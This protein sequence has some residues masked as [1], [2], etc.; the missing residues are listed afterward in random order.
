MSVTL[1]TPM[2]PPAAAAARS[3][4]PGAYDRMFYSGTA[5]V[6]AL[7]V[8]VGFAPTFYLRRYFGA[9]VSITGLT[10]L[11]PLTQIHGFV[12]SAWVVLFVIQTR[13]VASRHLALHRRLGVAGVV[14]AAAMV[15]VGLPTA[16]AAAARGSAPP[17]MDAK[18]FLVVPVF[19]LLL[20]AGFVTA[21]VVRRRDKETHKRLMLLGYTSI[22]PAAVGRLPGVIALGPPGLFGLS[23]LPAVAGAAYD[24]W[25]RGR[26]TPIYW[27][28]IALLYLSIPLRLAVAATPPWRAFAEFVTR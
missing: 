8:F 19:D 3:A 16:F 25:S 21:A 12:F 24:Y 27:W 28:G 20:F 2:T 14:L 11:S 18:V 26:V 6:L 23:F 5:L 7:I 10:A 22:L 1:R 9:P 13:L 15:L 17:G 4:A